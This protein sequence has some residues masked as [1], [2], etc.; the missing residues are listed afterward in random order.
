MTAQSAP[1]AEPRSKRAAA[2]VAAAG[3]I[4]LL[5]LCLRLAALLTLPQ[6]G[7]E[8]DDL[9]ILRIDMGSLEHFFLTPQ[10]YELEQSRLPFLISAPLVLAFKEKALIPLRLLFYACHLGYL[11]LSFYLVWLI[12]GRRRAALVYVLLLATSCY[13]ASFSI[14]AITTGDS[15]Y[16]LFHI[17]A[18]AS[19]LKSRQTWLAAGVF[20][21]LLRLAVLLGACTASKLFGVLLLAALALFDLLQGRGAPRKLRGVRPGVLLAAGAVFLAALLLVNLAPP[22]LP[23]AAFRLR[24]ALVLGCGYLGLLAAWLLRE[25]RRPDP[26]AAAGFLLFWGA[27]AVTAFCTTLVLSPVYLNLRN[28]LRTVTW[29]GAWNSGPLVA[30]SRPGDMAIIMVLKYGLVSCAALAALLVLNLRCA[31]YRLR[32]GPGS[33]ICSSGFLFLL[34]FVIHFSIISL[35]RHKVTWYPLA[36]FPFLYL[37]LVRLFWTAERSGSRRLKTAV[38]LCLALIVADNAGR[39]LYW[40]PYGHF[41]GAQYGREQIGWNRAGFIT[42]EVQ[43][44]LLAYLDTLTAPEGAQVHC[45]VVDVPF[46][47]TWFRMLLERRYAADGGTRYRFTSPPGGEESFDYL[48]TSPVYYPEFE[49]ALDPGQVR[50]IETFVIKGI[51]V[52]SVWRREETS[53][54]S[55]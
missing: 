16:L 20:P 39:Y 46:Y 26:P 52:L 21:G 6:L 34:V 5:F 30:R 12:T 11:A 37:P 44:D 47:N 33:V 50:K 27:V 45:R 42:F 35:T 10:T 4:I 43:P 3:L 14:F 31:P 38:L 8:P 54:E 40:F 24:A 36:V 18:L 51:P 48:L 17:A 2:V 49:E 1:G 55:P 7:D 9:N 23:A 15:L 25:K 53:A 19:Y 32:G 41:D 13:L 29:F 22:P 28:L